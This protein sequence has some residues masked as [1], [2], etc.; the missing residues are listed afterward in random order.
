MKVILRKDVSNLGRS[1]DVK[2]VARGYA[3]NYLFARGLAQEATDAAIKANEKGKEKRQKLREKAAAEAVSTSKKLE[4][5]SLSY[6]RPAGEGGKLFGSV[7]KS[8]IVKSLKAS[9][10]VVDKDAVRLESAI[11]LAGE[12]EVEI[13]LTPEASTKIKVSILPRA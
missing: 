3:R 12:H 1:G 6:T 9:G 7:G 5:V 10:H 13:R 11:K 2:D 8:D 4:G